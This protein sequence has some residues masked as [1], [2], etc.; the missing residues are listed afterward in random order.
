V[1]ITVAGVYGLSLFLVLMAGLFIIDSLGFWRTTVVG[2]VLFW[3]GFWVLGAILDVPLPP[4]EIDPATLQLW[5]AAIEAGARAFFS[6]PGEVME[7]FGTLFSDDLAD[8]GRAYL[9]GVKRAFAGDAFWS[10]HWIVEAAIVAGRCLAAIVAVHLG[11][12]LALLWLRLPSRA[13]NT[14]RGN[15]E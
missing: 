15:D 6:A 11:R 5:Y 14:R 1:A 12:G 9:D 7:G 10:S 8:T 4:G 2:V 3:I 13:T